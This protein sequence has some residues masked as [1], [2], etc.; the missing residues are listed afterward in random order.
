MQWVSLLLQLQ[1]RESQNAG[2]LNNTLIQFRILQLNIYTEV[3]TFCCDQ[4][5][6]KQ[7]IMKRLVWI[8]PISLD[9]VLTRKYFLVRSLFTYTY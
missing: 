1:T 5:N 6:S 3:K 8:G 7:T 2:L 9:R 4:R